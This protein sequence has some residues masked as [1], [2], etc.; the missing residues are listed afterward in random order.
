MYGELVHPVPQQ[1]ELY[2][3]TADP[4]QL[5]NVANEPAYAA[6]RAELAARLAQMRGP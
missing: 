1:V 6:V 5:Q 4:Y 3:L 2:D